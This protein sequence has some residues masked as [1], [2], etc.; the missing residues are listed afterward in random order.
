MRI[1][2]E[3]DQGLSDRER[4]SG[5]LELQRLVIHRQESA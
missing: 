1:L 2:W 4:Y 3:K 5:H